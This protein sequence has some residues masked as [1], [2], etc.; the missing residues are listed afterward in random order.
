[1]GNDVIDIGHD[2]LLASIWTVG[3]ALNSLWVPDRAGRMASVVLGFSNLT[4]RLRG[5][6]YLGEVIGPYANR[7]AGGRFVLDGVTHELARNEGDTCLHGGPDAFN[8]QTWR[9]E[10]ADR[11]HVRL[12]LDWPDGRNGFPGPIHAEASYG[13]DGPTLTHTIRATAERPTVVNLVAHPYFNLSG[14]LQPV[15]DHELAVAAASYL[16]VTPEGIPLPTA[17]AP[18]AGSLDLR[19]P[20]LLGDVVTSDHPQVLRRGGLDFAFVLDT[21]A[22]GRLTPAAVLT[23]AGSGRRL[24]VET[25]FPALHV[26]SAQ[27][28]DDPRVAL[29]QGVPG[30][31]T[32]LALEAEEF[33]DAPNRPDFPST[34]LRPGEVYERTTRWTFSVLPG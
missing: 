22:A 23:H 28:L 5:V 21:P 8:R 1:M 3:A 7:I 10:A 15:H 12:A 13:V 32:G 14:R 34:L 27:G 24:A 16:P 17:P 2:R 20:R 26:Y 11:D 29:P 19:R 33:P 30:P 18:V 31:F 6:D 25:D 9:V 4:D